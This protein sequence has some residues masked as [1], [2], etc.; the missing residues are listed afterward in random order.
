MLNEVLEPC[1]HTPVYNEGVTIASDP[2][3][4]HAMRVGFRTDGV[5]VPKRE[6]AKMLRRF[7]SHVFEY[8]Y[9]T[10]T[11]LISATVSPG[12]VTTIFAASALTR[13][14]SSP[15]DVAQEAMAP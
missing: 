7:A 6:T 4:L 8:T 3:I 2:R 15:T 11:S 14:R 13:E 1:A 5:Q 10:M 12:E 9:R